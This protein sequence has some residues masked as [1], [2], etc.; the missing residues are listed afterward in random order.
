[1]KKIITF[2]ILITSVFLLSACGNSNKY[3]H[4]ITFDTLQDKLDNKES[5]ILTVI[6][7]GCPHCAVFEPRFE[8]VLNE[9]KV[10]AYY[11]NFTNISDQDFEKFEEIFGTGIGTPTTFFIENGQEK[12]KIN[13]LSG[14]P[15][16]KEI[17]RKLKQNGYISEE[18]EKDN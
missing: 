15:T 1:M 10:D 17:I 14:E 2:V 5:F 8:S 7:D 3:F 11:L 13:R 16:K 9:Y 4:K 6:Q 18:N 12:T